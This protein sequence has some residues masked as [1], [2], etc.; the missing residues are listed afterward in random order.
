[1]ETRTAY[2]E[3]PGPANTETTLRLAR[4]RADERGTRQVVVA[5]TWGDTAL[6]AMEVFSGFKVVIVGIVTGPREHDPQS[7][8]YQ[9]FSPEAK[10]AIEAKGGVVLHTTHAFGGIT[11]ALRDQQDWKT[12]PISLISTALRVFGRGM[13]VACEITMMAADSGLVSLTEDAIAIAGSGRGADTAVVLRPVNAHRF[14]DLKVK[15]IICKP[16]S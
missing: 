11:R 14:F 8:I 12:S 5:S 6:K 2:F 16:L 10:K 1:M 9:P 3:K 13:K 7:T 4:E 15:E